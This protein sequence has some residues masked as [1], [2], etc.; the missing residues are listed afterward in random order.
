MSRLFIALAFVVM[1]ATDLAAADQRFTT[2]KFLVAAPGLRD[3]RFAESV[4][5]VFDHDAGGAF[6]LIVNKALGEGPLMPLLKGL[7]I[8]IPAD[9]ETGEDPPADPSIRLHY[10][11]PVDRGAIFIIHSTDY[12]GPATKVLIDIAVMTRDVKVL[13]DVAQGAGPAHMM[14][15]LGYAGWAAGQLDSELARGDWLVVPADP[16][17]LFD[18]DASSKWRRLSDSVGVPL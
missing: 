6:G 10:G 12:Q 13:R 4:V 8:E 2:G 18:D 15:I 5:L 14:M 9:S 16:M 1:V 7:E 11:G 17:I 3:P